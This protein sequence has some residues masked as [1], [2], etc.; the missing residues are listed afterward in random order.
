MEDGN[1][2]HC[3]SVRGGN[4]PQS[5]SLDYFLSKA[6]VDPVGERIESVRKC[7][8]K[9]YTPAVPDSAIDECKD[10]HDAADE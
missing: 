3:H 7:P 8:A 9:K 6:Q 2:H 5:Y 1:F 10:A 4:S